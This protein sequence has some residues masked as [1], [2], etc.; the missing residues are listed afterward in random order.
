MVPL[1]DKVLEI[2][3]KKE[4]EKKEEANQEEVRISKLCKWVEECH[5]INVEQLPPEEIMG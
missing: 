2:V 4:A 5:H 1:P 3:N